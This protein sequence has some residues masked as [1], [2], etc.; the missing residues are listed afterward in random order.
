MLPEYL[1][2]GVAAGTVAGIAYGLYMLLVGNPLSEYVRAAADEHGAHA[3]SEPATIAVSAGGGLLW[4]ILLGGGFALALYVF[5]PALPG[6]GETKSYVLAAAGFL[7]V[8]G[9]PWL[10][11]P[12]AAPGAAHAYPVGTRLRL[13]AGLVGLGGVAIAV[14]VLAYNRGRRRHVALGAVAAAI[15]LLAVAAAAL[16]V[17]TATTHPGLD[18]EL[19]AA[20]RGLAV[21]SQAS[22]WLLVAGAFNA[23]RRRRS[24]RGEGSMRS[25][26]EAI[27][28]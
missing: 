19:V 21:L 22:I 27:A 26:P 12:P 15:P 4:A 13:Y 14:A 8:S 9:I 16:A 28:G 23:L 11:L 3:V 5:E 10:A 18:G 25:E 2:R 1:Q 20:Y 24:A 7:T 17:P 6:R